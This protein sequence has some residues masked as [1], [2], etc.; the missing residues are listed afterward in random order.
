M[1]S[2][3]NPSDGYAQ[4]RL[5]NYGEAWEQLPVWN[6]RVAPITAGNLG[7]GLAPPL[8]P[9]AHALAIDDAA[10]A[11]DKAALLRLGQAAFSAYPVQLL[12]DAAPALAS[13]D[14][15]AAY[16]F[17]VD[18]ATGQVGGLVRAEMADGSSR[19]A[20]TCATCHASLHEGALTRGIPNAALDLGKLAID[21]GGVPPNLVPRVLAWGPGRLDVSSTDATEPARIPDLRPV[22]DLGYLQQ[23]ATVRQ[24]NIASLALRIETLVITSQSQV[25]RPPREVTMG[26]ALAVWELADHLPPAAPSGDEAARGLAVVQTACASCHVPDAFTGPPV[27]LAVVGTDPTL[28]L[29]PDRGTGS[30]RVPSLRGAGTR[31][32]LLHDA[33]APDLDVFF[34]P[35][36]LD[37]DYTRGR[38][39]GPVRGHPFNID[40]A[41]ADRQA[42]LAYLKGL[43]IRAPHPS[44]ST[45]FF[46]TSSSSSESTPLSR[47]LARRSSFS[48]TSFFSPR[49]PSATFFPRSSSSSY[50]R[51]ARPMSMSAK[52]P[53]RSKWPIATCPM[54][55]VEAPARIDIDTPPISEPT[56]GISLRALAPTRAT[57]LPARVETHALPSDSVNG[58]S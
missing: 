57:T 51:R 47:S 38:V 52:V 14:A 55:Y 58:T 56:P 34:D 50:I 21:A 16:G 9:D 15:A 54:A 25:I 18:P 43:L 29:S 40:L 30:Y 12:E 23:D 8:G 39:P 41:E 46:C 53:P 3:V 48:M 24:R 32:P 36:R 22:R 33:S 49:S 7:A 5:Q 26:L 6:P 1:A 45:R 20:V 13:L 11:G 27:P 31:G 10:Q 37:P 4:L 44:E 35:A 28:G 17:A 42:V 2:L 19:V